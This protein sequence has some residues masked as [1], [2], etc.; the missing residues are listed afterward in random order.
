MYYYNK[1]G[2]YGTHVY[3]NRCNVHCFGMYIYA[4]GKGEESRGAWLISAPSGRLDQGGT[5]LS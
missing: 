4:N 2:E 5:T 3:K 1:Y